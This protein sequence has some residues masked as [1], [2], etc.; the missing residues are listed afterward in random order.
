MRRIGAVAFNVAN[1]RATHAAALGKLVLRPIEKSAPGFNR[2]TAEEHSPTKNILASMAE[3]ITL[4]GNFL[5]VM[6]CSSALND[7][8]F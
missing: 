6:I 3:S 7:V 4:N 8:I 1:R 5:K 2:I